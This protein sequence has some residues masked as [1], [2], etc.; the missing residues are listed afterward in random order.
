MSYHR[1]TRRRQWTILEGDSLDLLKTYPDCHFDSMVTDPPGGLDFQGREWDSNRGGFDGWTAWF[2]AY[3]VQCYRVLK[4]G[5]HILV[6]AFPR[7]SHWTGAAIDR[8]GFAIKDVIMHLY[9]TGYPAGNVNLGEGRGTKLKPSSEPWILARKPLDHPTLAENVKRWGTGAINIDASRIGDK[10]RWPTNTILTHNPRCIRAWEHHTQP[11]RPK[12]MF[13]KQSGYEVIKEGPVWICQDDCPVKTLGPVSKYFYIAKPGVAERNLGCDL[14]PVTSP[15]V[16]TGGRKE[17]SAGLRNP[18]AGAGRG[19]YGAARTM[20][21]YSAIGEGARNSHP[22]LKPLELCI[23]LVK[24]VTPAGGIVLDPF[25]G[26]GTTGMACMTVKNLRFVGMEKN[27]HY[28]RIAR[29]RIEH[30]SKIS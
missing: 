12:S 20:R 14:I 7:T 8:A 18:A 22:T 2:E 30:V 27:S 24:M 13:L 15:G 11:K 6:W 17:G 3:M 23:Y 26:S 25:V 19:G 1:R 4:P 28:A 21:M 10:K 29:A 16:M 9:G 5:A